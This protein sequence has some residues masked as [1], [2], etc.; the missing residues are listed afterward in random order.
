[1]S[2]TK[3]PTI[4][5]V[6]ALFWHTMFFLNSPKLTWI[7]AFLNT[8][9]FEKGLTYYKDF[10][11]LH[12]PLPHLIAYPLYR[13]TNWNILVEPLMAYIIVITTTYLVY[14]LTKNKIGDIGRSLSLIFFSLTFWKASTWIQYSGESVIGI[15]LVASVFCLYTFWKSSK[16]LSIVSFLFGF[17]FSLSVLSGQ[18]VIPTITSLVVLYILLL[19]KKDLTKKETI[20]TFLSL[21][22]G[23]IIPFTIISLYFVSKTAFNDFFFWN[24]PYYLTYAKLA[25]ENSSSLPWAEI[26]FFFSPAILLTILAI[27]SKKK[28]FLSI[29]LIC[30]SLPSIY[31][32]VKSIFHPHHLLFV[33]PILAICLGKSID[34]IE[35]KKQII[36]SAIFLLFIFAYAVLNLLPWHIYRIK[37]G[38]RNY[39]DISTE[40]NTVEF[41]LWLKANIGNK[42]TTVVGDPM[43]YYYA[44]LTPANKYYSALPWHFLPIEKTAKEFE[45]KPPEYWIIDINYLKRFD[46]PWKATKVRQ[47]I[48]NKIDDCCS[49][50]Y[51]N[52]PWQVWKA[53]PNTKL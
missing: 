37:Q 33:L 52:P 34:L 12:F 1:V 38:D 13:F 20:M 48:S 4:T 16:R 35:Q 36:I 8:W 10:I 31:F 53:N 42:K 19:L 46:G 14:I 24:I 23:L 18:I 44:N 40:K 45:Y 26:F 51:E 28:D 17:L 43:L 27:T 50:I 2:K 22:L 41:T 25:R 11:Q 5:L 9:F 32:I 7:P 6:V 21:C 47:F 15:F 49:L 30:A 39:N 29:I 3:L